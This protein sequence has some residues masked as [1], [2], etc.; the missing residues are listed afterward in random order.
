MHLIIV[1][2][3]SKTIKAYVL[4]LCRTYSNV[5]QVKQISRKIHYPTPKH[6]LINARAR[7]ESL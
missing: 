4:F 1:V 2:S 3:K 6:S 7:I 5:V